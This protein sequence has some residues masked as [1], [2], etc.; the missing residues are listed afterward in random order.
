VEKSRHSG[1]ISPGRSQRG[2][3]LQCSCPLPRGRPNFPRQRSLQ[4][5]IS[6]LPVYPACRVRWLRNPCSP[7]FS[8]CLPRT[9]R[10]LPDSQTVVERAAA[11]SPLAARFFSRAPSF[12]RP[13][14][15]CPASANRLDVGQRDFGPRAALRDPGWGGHFPLLGGGGG[16][17]PGRLLGL[18]LVVA[19][20]QRT[21]RRIRGGPTRTPTCNRYSAQRYAYSIGRATSS[22][23]NASSRLG[24]G[25]GRGLTA[26]LECCATA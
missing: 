18:Q 7:G 23:Q 20:E 11:S 8:G 22:W 16:R 13:C 21:L 2:G 9:R 1:A 17:F 19:Q 6:S 14:D 5:S 26:L 15:P 12:S 10:R 25:L 24:D 3:S 4:G